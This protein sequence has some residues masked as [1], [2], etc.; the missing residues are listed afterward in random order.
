V[1]RLPSQIGEGTTAQDRGVG[2]AAFDAA[3]DIAPH[4]R[5]RDPPISTRGQRDHGFPQRIFG[6]LELRRSEKGRD[7]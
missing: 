6:Q 5:S 1:D 3:D 4:Q 7:F 2:F